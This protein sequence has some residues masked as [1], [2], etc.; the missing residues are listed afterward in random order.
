M[1]ILKA[2]Y[3]TANLNL[4]RVI[5]GTDLQGIAKNISVKKPTVFF[6]YLRAAKCLCF[7]Y[8][9]ETGMIRQSIAIHNEVVAW[10]LRAFCFS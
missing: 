8:N 4:S 7:L 3:V 10:G 9:R 2:L 1:V 6:N 5:F